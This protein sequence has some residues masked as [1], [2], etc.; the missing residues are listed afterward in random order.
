MYKIKSETMIRTV[1]RVKGKDAKLFGV[2]AGISRSIDPS[3][4]PAIVRLIF[5]ILAA[6]SGFVF[7]FG[8]YFILAIILKAEVPEK[9]MYHAIKRTRGR[10]SRIFGVLGGVTRYLDPERDPFLMRLA[11]FVLAAL[12]GFVF[13]FALYFV[14]AILLHKEDKPVLEDE[15]EPVDGNLLSKEGL[16]KEDERKDI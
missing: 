7:M 15:T 14:L 4:D 8:L 3:W 6:L 9:P 1:K 10:G 13:M 12:S 11:F 16:F 5:I 2:C